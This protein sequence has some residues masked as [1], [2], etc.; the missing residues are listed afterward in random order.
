MGFCD[1]REPRGRTPPRKERIQFWRAEEWIRNITTGRFELWN[2]FWSEMLGTLVLVT[3]GNA[4]VAQNQAQYHNAAFLDIN[5]AYGLACAAGIYVAARTSGGHINP[6][7]TISQWLLGRMNIIQAVSTQYSRPTAGI[8]ATYPT[9]L[10]KSTLPVL[11]FD[12]CFA[13]VM[14]VVSI[15]ALLDKRNSVPP[16]PAI[17]ILI[18][19]FV[20]M[21]GLSFGVNAGYAINPARDFGPRLFS[22]IIY[23]PEVFSVGNY[24]FWIPIL[25]PTVGAIIGGYT[26]L[27]FVGAYLDDL[28]EPAKLPVEPVMACQLLPFLFRELPSPGNDD[29]AHLAPSCRGEAGRRRPRSR[30]SMIGA[31]MRQMHH[32]FS[33]NCEYCELENCNRSVATSVLTRSTS[34]RSVPSVSRERRE[35]FSTPVCDLDVP[36]PD[37]LEIALQKLKYLGLRYGWLLAIVI[38]WIY[39]HPVDVVIFSL[40]LHTLLVVL[41]VTTILFC[42]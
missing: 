9:D 6:A 15:N 11:F 24:Y 35:R 31:E 5:L 8:F 33:E 23:G 27:L 37:F 41:T 16:M 40:D 14:L 21:I 22:A 36:A 3:V 42:V 13:T 39:V 10:Y 32:H 7:V 20:I 18:G 28:E 29:R 26:Y 12:Q 19:L 17:P 38:F 2:Q 30:R 4:S 25:A 34:T 1:I